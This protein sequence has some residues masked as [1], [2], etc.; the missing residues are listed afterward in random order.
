MSRTRV[1]LAITGLG[2]TAL[3]FGVPALRAQNAPM[4]RV[5]PFWPKPLPHKWIMQQVPTLAV[6][7]NDHVWVLNRSRQLSPRSRRSCRTRGSPS[8]TR[9]VSSIW[10]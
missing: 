9:D 1:L 8:F 2:V 4:Y 3:L 10:R 7:P 6:G 5:D